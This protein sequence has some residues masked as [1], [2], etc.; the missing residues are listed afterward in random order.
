M[1]YL[2]YLCVLIALLIF[3]HTIAFRIDKHRIQKDMKAIQYDISRVNAFILAIQSSNT[4]DVLISYH[5]YAYNVFK[6]KELGPCT[7][8]VRCVSILDL[9]SENVYL[10]LNRQTDVNTSN[11]VSVLNIKE[12]ETL[13]PS[14]KDFYLTRYRNILI[15]ALSK[16]H[17]DL[18]TQLITYAEKM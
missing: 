7:N 14:I 13:D 2:L 6:L 11:I 4:F 1:V 3:A 9:C 8:L 10:P 12:I 18:C 15:E 5:K 17:A 16:K